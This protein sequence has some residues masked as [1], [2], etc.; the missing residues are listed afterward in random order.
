MQL[1]D[2]GLIESAHDISEGGII[3]ALAECCII[4]DEKPV[5]CEVD[6]PVKDS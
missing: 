1:I 4:E 2:K 6:I 5:G 3:S